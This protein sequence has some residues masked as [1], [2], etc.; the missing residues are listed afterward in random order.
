MRKVAD[1][2]CRKGLAASSWVGCINKSAEKERKRDDG[3]NG[4]TGGAPTGS[5][6]S[7]SAGGPKRG[8]SE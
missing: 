3:Q 4:G 1:L 2:G 6:A 7:V 5:A 8:R